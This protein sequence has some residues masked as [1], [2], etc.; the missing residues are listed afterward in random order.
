MRPDSVPVGCN[1]SLSSGFCSRDGLGGG[2][3]VGS[4][5]DGRHIALHFPQIEV[6][7]FLYP[8]N[9]LL[10]LHLFLSDF[11]L[12]LAFPLLHF[13]ERIAF[14]RELHL[15]AFSIGC[16]LIAVLSELGGLLAS[17]LTTQA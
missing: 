11:H 14:I 8:I 7:F 6:V 13:G 17:R 5:V 3:A 15:A 9:E 12:D 1:L 2:L 10:L 4:D 16:L